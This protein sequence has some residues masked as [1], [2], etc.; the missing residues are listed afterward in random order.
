M[1]TDNV[2]AFFEK[3]K[4]DNALKAKLKA[5]ADKCKAQQAA[6]VGELIQLASESG[7]AFTADHLQAHN[8]AQVDA[9]TDDQLK[10]IA[11]GAFPTPVNSQI[12]DSVTQG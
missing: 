2:K 6:A 12:T 11:G 3:A 10:S 9:L 1:S 8:E 5:L 4:T 7:H